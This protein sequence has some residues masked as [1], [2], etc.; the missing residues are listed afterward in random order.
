MKKEVAI[1]AVA[2]AACSQQ[3]NEQKLA[4]D[5]LVVA[6]TLDIKK[7]FCNNCGTEC[8]LS[9]ESTGGYKNIT[10][11][12]LYHVK[13]KCPQATWYNSCR[14]DCMPFMGDGIYNAT[15]AELKSQ[16]INVDK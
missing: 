4:E 13:I 6:D 10:G 12:A 3:N 11:E 2:L 7:I 15:A 14:D 9:G 1:L 8:R 5:K 16:G